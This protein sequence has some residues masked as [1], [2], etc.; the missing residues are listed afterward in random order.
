MKIGCNYIFF[1]I[2]L[3]PQDVRDRDDSPDNDNVLHYPPDDT[4]IILLIVRTVM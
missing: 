3:K 4:D 2:S 1:L